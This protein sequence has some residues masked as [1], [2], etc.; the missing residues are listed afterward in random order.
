MSGEWRRGFAA[1]LLIGQALVVV[2]GGSTLALVAFAIAPSVFHEHVRESPT[3]FTDAQRIHVDRA[4]QDATLIALGVAILV[5]VITAIAISGVLTV[6]LTRPLHALATGAT[7]IAGGRYDE[8]TPVTGPTEL[9]AL[10]E[11]FNQMA[12]ALEHAE[13]RRRVLLADIAH[14]LRTPLA[15]I[16]GYFEGLTD[17]AIAPDAETWQ[18]LRS[19]S[20][21]LARLVDDL[22]LV[23]RAEERQLHLR[24]ERIDLTHALADAARAAAPSYA[25]K[26]VAIIED[27][28]GRAPAVIAD[29]DR[30]AEVFANLL[31]NALRHT[32]PGGR[33][34]VTAGRRGRDAQIVVADTGEGIPPEH[35]GRVFDRFYRMDPARSRTTGGSGIGL[36]ITRAI[37]DAHGG[38]IRAESDGPGRGAR[39]VITLPAAR[40]A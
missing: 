22:S 16:E 25:E 8:R 38:S 14:E 12:G 7:R 6:R 37:V 11:S 1:R 18:V 23:S 34:T 24:R 35:L 19:E 36:T 21:R 27:Y 4:F 3:P 40:P 39:F 9:A 28:A 13:R 30:L 20:R 2:A 15:T 10:A 5:A 31:E 33:V 26:G 32:P 29:P 17:G